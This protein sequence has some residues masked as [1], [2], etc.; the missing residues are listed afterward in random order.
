MIDLLSNRVI[1]LASS[2]R[3]S[4][5][6][7]RE[8]TLCEQRDSFECALFFEQV[9]R[10]AYDLELVVPVHARERA[11]IERQHLAVVAAHDQQRRRRDAREQDRRHEVG[12][13]SCSDT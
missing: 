12:T 11:A 1:A 2:T 13:R 6:I 10:P 4:N 7:R 5:P 8:P 9:R 3:R